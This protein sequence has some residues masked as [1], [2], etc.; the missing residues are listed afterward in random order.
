MCTDQYRVFNAGVLLLALV[1]YIS[2]A[3]ETSNNNL[4]RAEMV[5]AQHEMK[6]LNL[7]LWQLLNLTH[8]FDQQKQ[9]TG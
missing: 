6:G 1:P 3:V 9:L 5:I 7:E 2:S 8:L 4:C